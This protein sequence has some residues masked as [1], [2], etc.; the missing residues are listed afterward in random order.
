MKTRILPRFLSLSVALFTAGLLTARGQD[1]WTGVSGGEWNTAGNWS[2]GVAP[3]SG[4]GALIPSGI[5]ANYNLVMAAPIFGNLTNSGVMNINAAGFNAT[6]IFMPASA[7]TFAVNNGGVANIAGN[8]A[9]GSNAL[10]TLA[11]GGSLTVAGSVL[12]GAGPTGGSSGATSG[13]Y[14]T[15]TISGGAFAAGATQINPG[16]GTVTSSSLLTITGGTANLGTLTIKKSSAGNGGYNAL[17]SEGLVINGGVVLMTNANVGGGGGNS[18]LTMW[19]E[20]GIATNFG[21]VS[22]NQGNAGRGS[23][24]IQSGGLFVVPSPGVINPN[25]TVVGSLNA[26]GI[27]G[28]TNVTDGFYFGS[29]NSGVGAT[30]YFTNSGAI[31]VGS[32]GI[33][34]NG[35]V[36]LN[37]YLNNGA[38]FGAT[39]NWTNSAT[40]NL[41]GGTFLFNPS[42]WNGNPYVITSTGVLTGPGGVTVTNAGTLVLA[43]GNT[44]TGPTTVS[45]GVLALDFN[46][47]SALNGSILDSV[48][49]TVNAGA[50]LDVSGRSDGTLPLASSQTLE[51]GGIILGTLDASGTVA[52]GGGPGG[53]IG[54]LSVTN[55]VILE[56]AS[57]TVMKLNRTNAPNNDQLVS[58]TA[59]IRF[60]GTLV[61]TNLGAELQV[62]DT[63]TLFSAASFTGS[64][65][66]LTLST[67]IPNGAC[68]NTNRLAAAGVISVST[69][70]INTVHMTGGSMMLNA[71]GAPNR[72]VVVL[73][74]TNL[75]LSFTHWTP[76]L[77]NYFDGNG[78]VQISIPISPSSPPEFFTIEGF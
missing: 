3:G 63:F 13:S 68:W 53:N 38:M 67:N 23:R 72:A 11:A 51:G 44:Y 29:S 36:L 25:P 66:A 9:Y 58:T 45:S 32:Q 18:F 28:G 60:G 52:P 35:A 16:N 46:T 59:G 71:V 10:V 19:M 6:G 30:V 62:G 1:T 61:A 41:T 40:L 49:V 70:S 34:S 20:N 27:M 31:Y 69:P 65:N 64:F 21:T 2:L 48:V 43:A 74:T 33:A 42:D 75:A 77:T 7:G 24:F 54:I 8:L 50:A 57:T 5:T 15:M 78:H 12:I 26:V 73:S 47:S 22:I 56:S 37:T 39:A 55:N 76:S 17:G 14:G 4:V